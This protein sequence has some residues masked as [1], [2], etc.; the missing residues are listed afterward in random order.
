MTAPRPITSDRAVRIAKGLA[1]PHC[2]EY[3]FKKMNVKKAPPSQQRALNTIWVVN[4]TC[5]VCGLEQELGIDAEG[6]IAY[7][8]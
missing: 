4:R 8:G 5:G 2:Q 6:E 1:C 7:T 3:S